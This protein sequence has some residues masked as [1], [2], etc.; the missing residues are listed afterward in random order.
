LGH[1]VG[2]DSPEQHAMVDALDTDLDTFFSWLDK[3]VDG[4][5]NNVWVALTADHGVAPTP[6]VSS[7]LG[8]KGAYLDLKQLTANLNDAINQKFSP[9]ENQ[10]YMLPQQELPYL[11][12]N[13]PVFAR[14]GINEQEAEQA[15]Q[16]V[17]ESA[18]AALSKPD[19]TSKPALSRLAPH[20][21]IYRSYTRQQ[22]AASELPATQFGQLVQHSYTPNG[23]WYVMVMPVAYQME[24]Y[25]KGT[26]TTHYSPYSYDRHVPL[27]FFGAPFA[28]GLYRG[29]VQPVDLAATFASLLGIN[30]PSASI[31]QVLNQALRPPAS[32]VYPRDTPPALPHAKPRPGRHGRRAAP[33]PDADDTAPAPARPSHQPPQVPQ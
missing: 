3:N 20:P 11:E 4:G 18:I 12:L 29:R 2:P 25:G 30:Q 26:G 24:G 32:V 14:A 22:M 6:A 1:Q 10:P 31:G 27:G 9:G 15:V 28:P 33:A 21:Q 23:G 7:A 17:I 5:L 16:N 19:D 8:L 13:E